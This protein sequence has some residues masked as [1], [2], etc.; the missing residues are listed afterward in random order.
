ML[1]F[2]EYV[3]A[4]ITELCTEWLCTEWLSS[5]LMVSLDPIG[6]VRH[7]ELPPVF[8]FITGMPGFYSLGL[9]S[10]DALWPAF[11]KIP[12]VS[13]NADVNRFFFSTSST[14]PVNVV[15]LSFSKAFSSDK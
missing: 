7:G 14:F 3:S 12:A 10:T 5:I 9:D 15:I 13:P 4:R 11:M 2:F 6:G 8:S 1:D